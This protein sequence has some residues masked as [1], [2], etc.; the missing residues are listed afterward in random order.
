MKRE[1]GAPSAN[2]IN[3]II[4]PPRA[5][6]LIERAETS[7]KPFELSPV[8]PTTSHAVHL[9]HHAGAML[10]PQA[11]PQKDR[12]REKPY[13]K[14]GNRLYG[15]NT[16]LHADAYEHTTARQHHLHGK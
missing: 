2:S 9:C 3:N 1:R 15:S 12:E 13:R 6:W 8:P 4:D 14:R 16:T 11:S 7:D 10:T 5:G